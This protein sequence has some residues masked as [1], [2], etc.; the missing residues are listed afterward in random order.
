MIAKLKRKPVIIGILS[1][2]AVAMVAGFAVPAIAAGAAPPWAPKAGVN[3]NVTVVQGTSF[4]ITGA[5]IMINTSSGTVPLGIGPSTNFN[6]HGN[7][8]LPTGGLTN[9]PVTAVYKNPQTVTPPVASQIM[10]NMP[11]KPTPGTLTPGAT[12][13]G[14]PGKS[15][16]RTQGTVTTLSGTPTP[17]SV[18]ITLTT[19][20]G[21][22]KVGQP[23]VIIPTPI[24]GTPNTKFNAVQGT[25]ATISTGTPITVTVTLTNG[26][27]S[28]TNG[29]TV[30]IAH[31]M[32]PGAPGPGTVPGGRFRG[33]T[34]SQ[35]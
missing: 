10:I 25:V 14:G 5:T 17:T 33:A 18:T 22:L 28:L 29:Q 19:S 15:F 11:P 20:V 2:I 9:E 35:S 7:G 13:P 34:Q 31:G 12:V 26:V 3:A 24:Q 27:G 32:V 1:F 16:M 8:W 21:S 30:D 6:A 4:T 23:V